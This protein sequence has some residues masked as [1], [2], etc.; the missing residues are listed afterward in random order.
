LRDIGGLRGKLERLLE[1][2]GLRERLS[3]S[4]YE[5]VRRKFDWDK[6]AAETESIFKTCVRKT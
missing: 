3:S 2:E 1:D 5:V 6:V 4:G